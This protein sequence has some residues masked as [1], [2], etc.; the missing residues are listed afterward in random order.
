MPLLNTADALYLGAQTVDAA[1]LGAE[2]VW[3]PLP[4][5]QPAYVAKAIDLGATFVQVGGLD[6]V[7]GLPLVGGSDPG[8]SVDGIDAWQGQWTFDMGSQLTPPG[9]TW[10]FAAIYRHLPGVALDTDCEIGA[11][12]SQNLSTK[13]WV[14]RRSDSLSTILRVY[15]AGPELTSLS[16]Y[17]TEQD[18]AFGVFTMVDDGTAKTGYVTVL[19]PTNTLVTGERRR[20]SADAG[21]L[22]EVYVSRDPNIQVA[23][24]AVFPHV[25]LTQQQIADLLA[26][27]PHVGQGNS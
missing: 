27:V 25:Y 4:P 2:Q 12:D 10:S 20:D 15:N 13:F 3:P 18:W 26:T 8:V 11:Q 24:V 14:R 22:N 5:V 16:P 23:G 21:V 17:Q 1:Y 9:G 19:D 6:Y 7:S